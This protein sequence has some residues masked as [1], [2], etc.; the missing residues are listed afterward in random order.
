MSVE[1][2]APV[3]DGRS[4]WLM[5][6]DGQTRLGAAVRDL[7]ESDALTVGS[8][9]RRDLPPAD[10]AAVVRV[11]Q[12]SM[13]A[14]T[15]GQPPG[16]WWT[17]SGGEQATHPLVAAGRARRLAGRVVADVTAGCGGDS[18]ALVTTADVVVASDL[19]A[20][21]LP[22][23]AHNLDGRAA[24]VRAD[25]LRPAWRRDAVVLADPGRRLAGRRLRRLGELL[26]SVPALLATAQDAVISL[27]PALDLGDPDLPA[28][29][30]VEFV[31]VD[32]HLVEATLWTGDLVTASRRATDAAT[33]QTLSG[34]P[35]EVRLEVGAAPQ[36]GEW[37]VEP[38]PAL[39]RSRL[40]ARAPDAADWRRLDERRALVLAS[41]PATAWARSTEVLAITSARPKA[42]RRALGDLGPDQVEVLLHGIETTPT[43]F[44]R[45]LGNPPTGPTGVRIHLVRTTNGAVAIITT[46]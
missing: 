2:T 39:V 30:E 13:R 37:L 38:D 46:S 34:D 19:D 12:A 20:A 15:A 7:A 3:D 40:V 32:G 25:A 8:R 4:G 14:W 18:L 29:G 42:V 43:T 31:Q 35:G 26:P 27:P 22:L 1:G 28:D 6:V 11:A 44:L 10:A 21:R 36:V 41:G 9:L 5:G 24:V 45:A 33:G 16:T 17:P 23:L